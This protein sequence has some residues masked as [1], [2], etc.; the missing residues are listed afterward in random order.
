MHTQIERPPGQ[1]KYLGENE[2]FILDVFY[3]ASLA[4][5]IKTSPLHHGKCTVRNEADVWTEKAVVSQSSALSLNFS[6]S[7]FAVIAF[8]LSL[9]FH[10]L[11]WD[12]WSREQPVTDVGI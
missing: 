4:Q 1:R 7:L 8:L 9:L 10:L 2:N 11:K 5:T 3:E 6:S 12:V